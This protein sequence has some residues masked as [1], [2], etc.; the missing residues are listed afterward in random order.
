LVVNST[1]RR[2]LEVA[3]GHVESGRRDDVDTDAQTGAEAQNRAGVAGDVGLVKRDAQR[4][5]HGGCIMAEHLCPCCHSPCSP[6]KCYRSAIAKSGEHCYEPAH[7]QPGTEEASMDSVST[8]RL[9]LLPRA[10]A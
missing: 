4:M 5:G 6:S 8:M 7:D 1:S 10:H 3:V 2:P 9:R